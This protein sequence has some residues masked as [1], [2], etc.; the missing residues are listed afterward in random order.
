MELSKAVV[1]TGASTGIGYDLCKNLIGKGYQVYGSVRKKDD[2]DRLVTELGSEFRP[3][4][5]DVTD[6][7]SIE[8]AAEIVEHEQS[9]GIACLIN[10]A[11]MVVGG[12]LLHVKMKDFEYQFEVNVFGLMKVTQVFAPLLGAREN[13]SLKPGRIIQISSVSG[14]VGFPFIGAYVGSKHAVEGLSNSLRRELVLWGIDVIVIGP[15][16]IRTAIWNKGKDEMASFES[17]PYGPAMTIFRDKLVK[18]S[19][20]SALDSDWLAEKIVSILESNKPK[21][22]YTFMAR[23]FTNYILPQILPPR[24]LDRILKKKL[25]M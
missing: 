20:K 2:A 5:F 8:K 18:K 17:T 11:G 25:G 1:I 16:A 19:L 22:R 21:T 7:Q 4:I 9:A 12:P 10:N 14:K 15:G 6:Y 3:L 23:K 24:M 13:H